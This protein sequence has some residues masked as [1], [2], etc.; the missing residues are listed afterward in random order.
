[1][2]I[3]AKTFLFV[4]F[5]LV[6]FS[7][8][9]SP[10]DIARCKAEARRVTIIRDNWG[11][12]HIY[13]K[14]DADAVFGSL[15]AQCEESFA[16]VEENNLEMLGRLAELY[17]EEQLYNDLQMR[18]IYD[19]AAAITDY[20][21]QPALVTQVAGR[22]SRW[23]ELLLVHPPRCAPKIANVFQAVVCAAADEW[24]YIGNAKWRHN[25]SRYATYVPAAKQGCF[26]STQ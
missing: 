2:N 17:G 12:P 15:Y 24:Q 14:T 18:L 5:P 4:V 22:G 6:S 8:T 25:R 26:L 9:L 1:M 23:S 19:T 10:A 20:K 16:K 13:G 3:I 21:R 7:Q 11:V